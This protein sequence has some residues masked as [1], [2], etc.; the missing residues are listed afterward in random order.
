MIAI[1]SSCNTTP[2]I[3]FYQYKVLR[4][5]KSK[6]ECIYT[7]WSTENS[8]IKGDNILVAKSDGYISDSPMDTLLYFKAI[9]ITKI[10]R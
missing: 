5:D 8:Y 9:I 10:D 3:P 6:D 1:L 4:A 2:Y 7:A